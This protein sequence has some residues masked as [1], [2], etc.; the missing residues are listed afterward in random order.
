MFRITRYQG[1][2]IKDHHLLLLRH[3]EHVTKRTYWVFPGVL[4]Y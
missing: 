1:A 4:G 3:L 2:I